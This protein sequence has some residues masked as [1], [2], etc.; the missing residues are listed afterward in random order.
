MPLNK[1]LQYQGKTEPA[2]VPGETITED[3]WHQAWS[4]P[5]RSRISGALAI[6]LITS[7]VTFVPI[8][9]SPGNATYSIDSPTSFEIIDNRTIIYPAYQGPVPTVIETITEDK[10]HHRWSEPL[11][12][13]I[14]PRS[15][16]ALAASSGG[17]F[18][19]VVSAPS[20]GTA[21]DAIDSPIPFGIFD[22]RGII[23]PS[24]QAPVPI[25]TAVEVLE[26]NW[27]QPWSI[28]VRVKRGLITGAQDASFAPV[29][30]TVS[31]GWNEPSSWSDPVRLKRGL[32]SALQQAAITPEISQEQVFEDKWHQ[33][34]SIPVRL[35][36][37]LITGAQQ[38]LALDPFPIPRVGETTEASWHYRWSEPVRQLRDPKLSVALISSGG[39]PNPFPLPTTGGVVASPDS[40]ISFEI[41]SKH[42]VIY[43][44]KAEPIFFA[45]ETITEDKWHFAWSEPVRHKRDPKAAIA[46]IASGGVLNP[47]PYTPLES[48]WHYPWSEPV[49]LKRG[50]AAT[51]Q[52]QPV[53]VRS[54]EQIFEDKWHQ[55]WSIPVRSRPR[56]ITGAQQFLAF[57]PFPLPRASTEADWH[58]PWSEPVRLRPGL[59][60]SEQQSLASIL[61]PIEIVTEDKWHQG[62]S[63]PV[64]V[65]INPQ[66][67]VALIASGGVLN[68][69]PIPNAYPSRDSLLGFEIFSRYHI[70]Y[71]SLHEPVRVPAVVVPEDRWHQPWSVPVRVKPG[72]ITGAQQFF[73]FY[74]FP[75]PREVTEADWHYPWSEPVRRRPGLLASEQQFLAAIL[76][77]IEIVRED[78]WHRPWSEPIRLALGPR[79][80]A[81]LQQT[82]TMPPRVLTGGAIT[83][84]L[85]ATEAGDIFFALGHIFNQVAGANVGIVE[86]VP[87]SALVGLQFD[88]PT[89]SANVGIEASIQSASSGTVVGPS[90]SALVSI[91]EV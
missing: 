17:S 41:F 66:Y 57:Y 42:T 72:L 60:A 30:P 61:R 26:S 88:K 50:L 44:A 15:F 45:A 18:V 43:Q 35:K 80:P 64:R 28:P 38:F 14:S 70:I 69:L 24:Y 47:L 20:P 46:L 87:V 25:V 9:P 63:E 58:Y 56:L 89:V 71:S 3:K 6:A 22:T 40:I 11:R 48:G 77:P 62:W 73:A 91:R 85:D 31:F 78:K 83:G 5:V 27:H 75:L 8:V 34:L 54:I 55:G 10:W 68:P 2:F 59:L 49:R 81:Y 74:P 39:I 12:Y 13:K 37:R 67:S 19:P 82:T 36:P 51:Q 53:L 4:E 1:L 76:R 29:K 23:Y 79:L 90:V 16:V 65:K 52:Q 32:G 86:L 33:P 21:T 7:G 84:I